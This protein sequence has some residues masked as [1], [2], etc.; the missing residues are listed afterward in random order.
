MLKQKRLSMEALRGSLWFWPMAVAVGAT[1]LTLCLLPL[2]PPPGSWAWLFPGDAQAASTLVQVVG[3][4]AMTAA[5]MTFS[6]TVVALQLA[7]QQ[8][9]PRLLREFA[10]DPV[11]QAVLAIL[12][13]SRRSAA[14]GPSSPC[15]SSSSPSSTCWASS[16]PVRSSASWGTSCACSAS[17]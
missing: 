10:R 15:P 7:S 11:T 16:R 17:T 9:S 13:A 2:R 6:L 3:T 12:S 8:F 5:T 1:A 4:A 14:S